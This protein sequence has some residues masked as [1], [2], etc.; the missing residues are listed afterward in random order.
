MATN[1]KIYIIIIY[2]L[3]AFTAGA[4]VVG[5]PNGSQPYN[6]K[7]GNCIWLSKWSAEQVKNYYQSAKYK[8]E[9][10][11]ELKD[12]TSAGYKLYFKHAGSR[13]WQKY[14]VKVSAIKTKD[15]I[16]YYKQTNPDLLMV[17]FIALKEQVGKSGHSIAD[18]KKVYKQY[19]HLACRLY[20]QVPDENGVLADE[21]SLLL[22]KYSDA[23]AVNDGNL[24]AMHG[25]EA[26]IPKD[27]RSNTEKDTWDYWLQFLQELDTIGYTTII[28][29]SISPTLETPF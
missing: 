1:Y 11:S 22:K 16:D 25:N 15:A 3:L 26:V 9:V 28:E 10:V 12:Q 8:P 21:M 27:I 29:Y 19:E 6:T 2:V 14:Q 24:L 7:D 5:V 17:P 4:Q 13:G 18:F 20:R 23:L